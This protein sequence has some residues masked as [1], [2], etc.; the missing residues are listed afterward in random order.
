MM[1]LVPFIPVI[2]AMGGNIGGQSSTII[3]RGFATGRVDFQNL[4]GFLLKELLVG[5]L[6][7]VACGLLVAVVATLWHGDLMLSVTVAASMV[8]AMATAAMLGV[9]VPFFFR[10]IKVDPAIAAGPLVTTI[11]DTTAISIYYLTALVVFA[12]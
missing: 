10:L 11:N 5:L 1:A 6:M 7:G 4:R 12:G 2:G 3:V 8:M 9:L